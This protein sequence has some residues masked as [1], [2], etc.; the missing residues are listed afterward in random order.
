MTTPLPSGG[1]ARKLN[2]VKPFRALLLDL[3]GTL[4]LDDQP[5]PGAVDAV[6]VLRGLGVPLRFT[7]N[8]TRFPRRILAERL[9]AMGFEVHAEEILTA[10]AAAATWLAEQGIRRVALYLAEA[11]FE[12]F[13]AFTRDDQRPEAV[14]IGD[15]GS[16]WSYDALNRAFRW[17]LAGARMVAIQKNR[18]WRVAGDLMLDAG[19]FVAA[20]E[21]ATGTSAVVVGKPAP[22]FFEAAMR[23]LGVAASEIAVVGDD[24]ETDVAGAVSAGC[25]GILVRTGKY[26]P[27]DERRGGR[28]PDAVLDSV[29]DLSTLPWRR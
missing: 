24:V 16:G 3:D 23:T 7:T 9:R 4:Y 6:A 28:S 21:Y 26:R 2:A 18:Y 1:A 22:A 10:P 29:A 13:H 8:T 27:G 5:L 12:E 20:L 15:L 17:L 25:R 19:P 11:S 14:V